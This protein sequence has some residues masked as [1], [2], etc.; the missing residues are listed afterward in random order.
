MIDGDYVNE[1]DGDEDDD[2]VDGL[3]QVTSLPSPRPSVDVMMM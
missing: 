3:E 1:D 2:D